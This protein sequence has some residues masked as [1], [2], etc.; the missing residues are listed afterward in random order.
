MVKVFNVHEAKTQFS[1]LVSLVIA[2][3]EVTIAKGGTPVAILS[4]VKTEA[5]KRTPG[6]HKDQFTIDESFFESMEL[7]IQ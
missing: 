6:T 3:E 7:D 5:R 1:K 2:G 4:P